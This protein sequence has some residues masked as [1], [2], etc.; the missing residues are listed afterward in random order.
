MPPTSRLLV[1]LIMIISTFLL[2][3]SSSILQKGLSGTF[4]D[5]VIVN[6]GNATRFV[7]ISSPTVAPTS[8]PRQF[9]NRTLHICG[10][11]RGDLANYLFPELK[12]QSHDSLQLNTTSTNNSL[13]V[14]GLFG[15]CPLRRK[16][17]RYDI[18][19]EWISN[20]W[21]GKTLSINGE[22][23]RRANGFVV[24]A[25]LYQIGMAPSNHN[26]SI[27]IIFAAIALIGHY[28]EKQWHQIFNHS[29]KPQST[30]KRFCVYAVSNCV[31]FREEAADAIAAL[32]ASDNNDDATNGNRSTIKTVYQGGQ[33]KGKNGTLLEDLAWQSK[34]YVGPASAKWA[35]NSRLYRDYRFCLVM[36]N[37]AIAGYI[38]EKI[39]NAFLAGCI[40][41][42]YGTEQIFDVFNSRAFVYYN[43][44]NPAPALERIRNLEDDAAALQQVMENEPILANGEATI[45]KYF[46]LADH[47]GSGNLK[48]KIR[49][50]LA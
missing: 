17:K 26:N 44:S 37:E 24:P 50:L 35:G 5:K 4:F 34:K 39:L 33:C 22:G 42:Y 1:P 19:I 8:D 41:I 25:N 7:A 46:S 29:L 49:F 27:Q 2:A 18:G 16:P 9:E 13:L 36:E 15:P 10:F 43:I 12:K 20:H 40:P 6:E 23:T 38:T 14:Y 31:D 47:V 48:N 28:P 30:K 32:Y 11:D 3:H 45:E 21:N